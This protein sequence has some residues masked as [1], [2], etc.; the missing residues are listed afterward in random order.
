MWVD[1]DGM[2]APSISKSLHKPTFQIAFAIAYAENECVETYF[3]ANNPVKGAPE[4]FVGNPMTPLNSESFWSRILQ[5]F[6]DDDALPSVRNLVEAVDSVF[7]SWS[8]LFKT[9]V[10]IPVSY[11]PPY[12]IGEGR[13]TRAAGLIQIR[14][15]AIANNLPSLLAGLE[16]VQERLKATKDKF[17]EHVNAR[18]AYF[19][20]EVPKSEDLMLPEKTKFERALCRRLALAGMLVEHLHDDP[21]FGRTKLAKI[22]YL[23]DAHE[24]LNLETEYYREAAGPLD[25]RALY[26]ERF[27]IEALAQKYD[28]F[29]SETKGKMV[30]YKPA[31]NFEKIPSFA[32]RHLGAKA[33]NVAALANVFEGLTTDQSEIVATL[34]ACWNDFLL[35]KHSPT[36]EEIVTEFLL[37]WH[38]KKSR[39]SRARLAK[40]LSWMRDHG[41]V[42]GGM[43]G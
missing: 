3:P 36:D 22:F 15:Y 43:E 38:T 31:A 35:Q 20:A 32:A 16:I 13:L 10:E 37:H 23:A 28:L 27:G 33:K 21:H 7:Q 6:T 41:I 17:F 2:W 42:L 4:L 1:A 19:G 34:Y 26:N 9:R 14:D 11:S 24:G 39:F 40:A 30:R 8:D 5:P 25:Q 18:L 29:W 12:F